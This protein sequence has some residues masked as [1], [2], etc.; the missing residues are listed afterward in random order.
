MA[1]CYEYEMNNDV[2]EDLELNLLRAICIQKE[3]GKTLELKCQATEREM[4]K[5]GAVRY[6]VGYS[7]VCGALCH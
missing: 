3:L 2:Q 5:F 1:D 4:L 7:S 6:R